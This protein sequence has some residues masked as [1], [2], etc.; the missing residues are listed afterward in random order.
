LRSTFSAPFIEFGYFETNSQVIAESTQKELNDRDP[1]KF[2]LSDVTLADDI[3]DAPER[4]DSSEK[5]KNVIVNPFTGEQKTQYS[6]ILTRN[7]RAGETVASSLIVKKIE[8][9]FN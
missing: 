3:K 9:Q 8:T 2:V 6:N 7:D 4:G 5:I 1:N